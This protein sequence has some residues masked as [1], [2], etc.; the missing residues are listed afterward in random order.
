MGACVCVYGTV[1]VDLYRLTIGHRHL[2]VRLQISK[3][4]EAK[5]ETIKTL[6][7]DIPHRNLSSGV[8]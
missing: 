8:T 4:E 7:M 6:P 2:V 1:V 5:L 3:Q